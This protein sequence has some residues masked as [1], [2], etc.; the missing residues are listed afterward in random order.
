M[1]PEILIVEDHP[2]MA[3]SI[4]TYV[5]SVH[6]NVRT[7][8]ACSVSQA[9]KRLS[10]REKPVLIIADLNLSDSS[11]LATLETLLS[12][13]P[14][15]TIMVFS[16]NDDPAIEQKALALGAQCFVSKS[17][18][19]EH[20]ARKIR[21]QLAQALRADCEPP[22][23]SLANDGMIATLTARQLAVL[24]E[25]A[26]GYSN[27]DI[28]Q[29]LKISEETVR[30]HLSDIFQRL[31]VQNRTQASVQYMTWAQKNDVAA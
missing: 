15:E 22:P 26:S 29:R 5:Q 27:R 13:A 14:R 25:I 16:M 31:G 8:V 30:T 9:R 12:L 17:S 20:F 18:L 10:R 23:S 3:S 4:T 1:F 24:A 11:G 2:M 7:V 21:E 28:A 19:P 6:P